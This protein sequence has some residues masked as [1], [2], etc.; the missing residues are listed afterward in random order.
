MEEQLLGQEHLAAA[1]AL[2]SNRH[3]S[4]VELDGVEGVS[5]LVE[6]HLTAGVLSLE[7]EQDLGQASVGSA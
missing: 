4:S 5:G 2:G 1:V 6:E 7:L 3:R